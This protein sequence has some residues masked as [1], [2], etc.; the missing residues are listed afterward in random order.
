M[1]KAPKR[2]FL[3]SVDEPSELA[4]AAFDLRRDEKRLPLDA[5]R[6][7]LADSFRGRGGSSPPEARTDGAPTPPSVPR[8]ASSRI[9]AFI[10]CLPAPPRSVCAPPAL[11]RCDDGP[12]RCDIAPPRWVLGPLR[13]DCDPSALLLAKRSFPAAASIPHFDAPAG[14]ARCEIPPSL[15]KVEAPGWGGSRHAW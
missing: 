14:S 9:V 4:V 12:A 5:D 1:R 2:V 15:R 11:R 10:G 7:S 8:S 6:E 13:C 3:R